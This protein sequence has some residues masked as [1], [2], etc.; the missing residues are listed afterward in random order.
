MKPAE[1]LSSI[2][3]LAASA[4]Q[5]TK[6]G[7]PLSDRIDKNVNWLKWPA[8][9][10]TLAISPLFAWALLRVVALAI[11]SPTTS[12]IPFLGGILLFVVLWRRWLSKS[13]WGAFLI[14]LEHESTHALFALL[15]GH[16][17][18]GFRATLGR[19][20]EVRFAGAGNW[21]ITSAPYFFPT[22]AIILFLL[23]FFLPFAALPWQSFLLGV[24]LAY[25]VISTWRETHRDQTDLQAMGTA[26]C[27]MF[28]PAA[29]LAVVGLLV[30]FS[31][32]GSEGMSKWFEYSREPLTYISQFFSLR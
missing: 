2:E 7:R 3:S 30:A 32:T 29:N 9:I 11:T 15:T 24:A 27:W 23:A 1:P 25:H 22:A 6:V 28:L 12:L 18:V 14:T 5:P 19:G 21:L 13:R 31:H 26:F 16:T 20:G 17:I 10:A 4:S 8:A